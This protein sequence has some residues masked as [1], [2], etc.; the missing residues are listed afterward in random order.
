MVVQEGS[1]E[2][3]VVQEGLGEVTGVGM[4]ESW[5]QG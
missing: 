5:A 1:E 2:M 3:E 4:T